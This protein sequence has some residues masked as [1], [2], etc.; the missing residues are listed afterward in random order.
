LIA[1][2]DLRLFK[3]VDDVAEIP[4]TIKRYHNPDIQDE[5]KHP[6]IDISP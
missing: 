2:D 6:D 3:I 1:P 4:E 5:F